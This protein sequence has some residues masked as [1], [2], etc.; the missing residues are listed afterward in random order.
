[1]K[2]NQFKITEKMDIQKNNLPEW[3]WDEIIKLGILTARIITLD[4]NIRKY[5]NLYWLS[6]KNVK[7]LSSYFV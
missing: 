3:T 2:D 7:E 6:Q 1:M 5:K 4:D